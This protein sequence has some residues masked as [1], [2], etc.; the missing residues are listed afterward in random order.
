MVGVKLYFEVVGAVLGAAH[1]G[2]AGNKIARVRRYTNT[3]RHESLE[4]LPETYIEAAELDILSSEAVKCAQRLG[5]EANVI[6]GAKHM[7]DA[8]GSAALRQAAE[9]RIAAAKRMS[10]GE[11]H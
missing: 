3:V 5:T 10:G 1:N 11:K 7:F 6:R 8:D 9:L 4:G 2:L